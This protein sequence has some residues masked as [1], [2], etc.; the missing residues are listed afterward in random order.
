MFKNTIKALNQLSGQ[1]QR[2][3]IGTDEE[4]YFD[5]EC[6]SEGCLFQFKIHMEDWRQIV[7]D[8]EVFCPNCA[9]AADS[10][11][12]WTQ[13]QLAHAREMAIH[14]VRSAISTGMRADAQSWNARHRSHGF[15]SMT[16]SV[17]SKPQQVPM[18][19]LALEPMRLKITCTQCQC[20][21]G[22]IGSA[23]FCPA[24]GHNAAD[25]QFEQSISGI[26]KT[27]EQLDV[28]K[29]AIPDRDAAE[30]TTR[31]LIENC[32]QNAVTAFQRV[33]EALHGSL[34][35]GHRVR[36]N[37][38]QNLVEG[39]Q[40][41]A[42]AI[43]T[44]YEQLL[45]IERLERLTILFQQ[46]HLLAHTQGIVDEDY[47][48]KSGDSRYRAGQRIVVSS[49]DVSEIVSLLEQLTTSLRKAIESI[50]SP[51]ANE[52]EGSSQG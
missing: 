14:Q 22:V 49:D 33:M 6:P 13:E 31:L 45:P 12:W 46:R 11:K 21:Y 34:K 44:R 5:R 32:L 48:K 17:N 41:W 38:F 2:V 51:T 25:H 40:L 8:E 37:A 29:S 28:V 18:P 16:M 3:E 35:L 15:I 24:C 4:G 23:Y 42:D 52:A 1:G 20:R 7:R 27:I 39:S 50:P 26:K 36:R 47:V 10:K 9:H 19:F 43:G 30:Y